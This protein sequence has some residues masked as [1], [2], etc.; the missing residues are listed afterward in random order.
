VFRD[1]NLASKLTILSGLST[2][3]LLLVML[4]SW[5]AGGQSEQLMVRLETAAVPALELS[6]E[7]EER[8]RTIQ[9]QL[10]AAVTTFDAGALAR[11]DRLRDEFLTRLRTGAANPV[12]GQEAM[13]KLEAEFVVYY[14]GAQAVARKLLR[15]ES[16]E[17][18]SSGVKTMRESY[19]R[20]T[21]RMG[22]NTSRVRQLMADGF[23]GARLNHRRS[24]RRNGAIA[25]AC[26]GLLGGMV[27]FLSR[28]ISRR[29]GL[30]V[31]LA[32][33]IAAG[34]F[35]EAAFGQDAEDETGRL[36]R[37][38][39][40]MRGK[41]GR[42]VDDLQQASLRVAGSVAQIAGSSTRISRGAERQA[43]AAADTST[44]MEQMVAS[45]QTVAGNAQGLASFVDGTTASI[46]EMGASIQ[47]V[48][49]SADTLA[50]TASEVSTTVEQMTVSATQ[51]AGNLQ[52]LAG[53][54]GDT[55]MT[56][57]QLIS[58]VEAV[59]RNAE[60]LA[61]AVQRVSD[62]VAGLANAVAQVGRV[63]DE[64]DRI[65]RQASQD[66]RGGDSA[67]AATLEGMRRISQTMQSTAQVITGLGSR[68]RE[69]GRILE[70]IEEMADQTNLLALNASIEAARAGEAGRGFAVVADE[71]RKLAERSVR[72]ANEIGDVVRQVQQETQA[73]VT[74]A[75]TGAA[76]T[77][78][79]MQLADQAGLALRSILE[80]VS[81]SSS[82]MQEIA[83]ATGA[84]STASSDVL[85]TV[86]DMNTA[87]QQVTRAMR[88][89]AAGS[90]QIRQAVEL[91]KTVT[92][93]A[94]GSTREQAE[95]GRQ[96]RAAV[97][98]L[99]RIA[100]QVKL[101]T[102]EQAEGSRQ[103]LA[104]VENMNRMTQ[105]VS[106]AT[107]E[108]KQG[109]GRVVE[110]MGNIS[111]IA[112]DNLAAVGEMSKATLDLSAE[113][114]SLSRLIAIFRSR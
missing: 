26:V 45:I 16:G 98:N 23:Q 5:L 25:L 31:E 52:S 93:Q 91:V 39:Q 66:A 95:G 4:M 59:A 56:I 8:L 7:Q 21:A 97:E 75:E 48:A 43:E 68:S 13:E 54:V 35:S 55:S 62:T 78:E 27:I 103:I 29:L 67:V 61:A 34:D 37:A 14:D 19:A 112:R 106:Q 94:A 9:E 69:I 82:L 3:G 104:A 20:L 87:T 57:E 1:L 30:A 84:Q 58:S 50:G 2:A 60:E 89:Q 46:S 33:R 114:E 86:A 92:G 110:A 41:L 11:T 109:G 44:S 71:V 15:E 63:A 22:E 65:S 73:A 85:R 74:T 79:G 76:E 36:L 64:A 42:V 80:S 83:T 96:L 47:Q 101:A 6:L 88:E 105:Q 100:G 49:R 24:M 72:A 17:A 28:D 113:A 102:K 90:R 40:I 18:V 38:M 70:V 12:L 32:D 53:T 10:G 99:N 81:R 108:Q 111:A 77:R 51:V 107:A